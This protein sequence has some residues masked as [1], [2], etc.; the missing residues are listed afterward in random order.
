MNDPGSDF[1]DRRAFV[2]RVKPLV[3]GMAS[4][5]L[6]YAVSILL[7]LVGTVSGDGGVLI[8]GLVLGLATILKGMFQK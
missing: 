2:S 3:S 1:S 5:V 4:T 7:V 6:L 8:P